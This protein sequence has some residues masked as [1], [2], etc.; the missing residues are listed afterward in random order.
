LSKL[1]NKLFSKPYF[2]VSKIKK[3]EKKE[4][5]IVFLFNSGRLDIIGSLYFWDFSFIFSRSDYMVERSEVIGG[6]VYG[7]YGRNVEKYG[8]SC[9][10]IS[11]P[12]LNGT[13]FGKI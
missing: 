2:R 3:E 4:F 10:V 5:F 13:F 7:V 1:K 8:N 12:F 6:K 9:W 11:V